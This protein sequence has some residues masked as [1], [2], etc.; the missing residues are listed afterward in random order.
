MTLILFFMFNA[1]SQTCLRVEHPEQKMQMTSQENMVM[2][3]K[4]EA[5]K[6]EEL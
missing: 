3:V 5:D 6:I 4:D 2:G 1:K